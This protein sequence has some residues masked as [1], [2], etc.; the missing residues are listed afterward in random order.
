MARGMRNTSESV[1]AKRTVER[2]MQIAYCNNV[3]R[4]A[5][6]QPA[7][8]IKTNVKVQSAKTTSTVVVDKDY[9]HSI[10][11]S[12]VAQRELSSIVVYIARSMQYSSACTYTA[13][14]CQLH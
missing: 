4:N 6:Q 1:P 5:E 7:Q 14:A 8:H 13:H 11:A 12:T 3:K 10:L 2:Q 9:Q